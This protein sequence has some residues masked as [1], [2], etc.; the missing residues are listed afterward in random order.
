MRGPLSWPAGAT[1]HRGKSVSRR[2]AERDRAGQL[3]G[4]FALDASALARAQG[5]EGWILW[6]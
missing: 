1:G 3:E 5:E 4:D 6:V 2:A